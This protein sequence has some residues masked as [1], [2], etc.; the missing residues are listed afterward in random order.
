MTERGRSALV[1]GPQQLAIGPSRLE[2]TGEALVID[3]AEWTFPLPRRLLGRV[4]VRPR[5]LVP[6][7]LALDRAGRH[8][9]SPIATRAHVE[10]EFTRPR[11]SWVGQG[12]L[13]CNWGDQPLEDGFVAWQW[14]RAHLRCDD[15]VFYEGRCRDG[16]PF[17]HGLRIDAKGRAEPAPLPPAVTLPPTRWRVPRC[18]RADGGGPVHIRRTLEDTPFYAR[19]ALDTRL[20]GEPAEGIHESIL[21]D[22]L[23]Q[24]IVRLMLPFR[25]P[26]RPR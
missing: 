23:R 13:D 10:V 6:L 26:R 7:A 25:M 17:A 16:S 14:S 5:A 2:W 22:R 8:W 4:Q 19:T 18:T 21:L 15:L 12:Y 11:W 1:R 24:P 3:V 9:W 20:M